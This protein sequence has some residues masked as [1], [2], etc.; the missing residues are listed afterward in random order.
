MSFSEELEMMGLAPIE[1]TGIENE[2]L[3][4]KIIEELMKVNDPEINVDIINLGLVYGVH[5]DQEKNLNVKM[6]LTAIGCPLAGTITGQAEQVLK[7]IPEI[8]QVEVE[9]VWNP[10]WDRNRVSKIASI[11]LGLR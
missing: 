7:N 1:F 4:T 11:Q 5:L 3:K 2:D 6:T 9:I 10:P 8:K